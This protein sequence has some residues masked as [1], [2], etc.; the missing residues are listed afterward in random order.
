MSEVVG[1][2]R[3]PAA[4]GKTVKGTTPPTPS[5]ASLI[6]P[7]SRRRSVGTLLGWLVEL[8]LIGP[9]VARAAR[10][11]NRMSFVRTRFTPFHARLLRRSRGRLRRSWMFAGGQPVMALTTVGRRSGRP[12][13]TVVTCFAGDDDLA[14]AGMNLGVARSPAWALNLEKNPEAT[15]E[16]RGETISV[17]ARRARDEEA[18]RLWRRWVELQPSAR[19]FREIAGREIPLFV[20]SRRA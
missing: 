18:A 15:I 10:A 13:T 20:L 16:L 17:I 7:D 8:P 11:P 9:L 12:R 6:E 1:D 2:S 4:A 19:A 3:A 5:L 14:C